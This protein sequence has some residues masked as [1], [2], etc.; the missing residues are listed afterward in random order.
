MPRYIIALLFVLA[1]NIAS[2][3]VLGDFINAYGAAKFQ[4]EKSY[5]ALGVEA[6]SLIGQCEDDEAVNDQSL[7]IDVSLALVN[8]LFYAYAFTQQTQLP[9]YYT[10]SY[11]PIAA[12][13]PLHVQLK[14][15]LI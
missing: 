10:H 7:K 15:F 4:T 8:Q 1:I 3:N 11:V 5:N 9:V 12:V 14:V 2:A 6:A 13:T